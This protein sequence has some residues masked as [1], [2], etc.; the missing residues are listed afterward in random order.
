MQPS[1]KMIFSPSEDPV[2]KVK[3][4]KYPTLEPAIPPSSPDVSAAA[5][6]AAPSQQPATAM[7]DAPPVTMPAVKVEKEKHQQ[8]EGK[9]KKSKI[10]NF[11]MQS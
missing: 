1:I 11:C 4:E 3:T 7:L 5:G 8:Q 9:G 10:L 6:T 2:P